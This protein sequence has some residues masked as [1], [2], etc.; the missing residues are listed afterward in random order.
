MYMYWKE[1]NLWM[2]LP[3]HSNIVPFDRVVLDELEGLF[4]AFTSV[5]IPGKSLKDNR[6]RVFKLPW[7]RQLTQVVDD[8]NLRYG[9][10]HQDIAPRNI[11]VDE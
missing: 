8:L 7:L 2:R 6:S 1:L 9:I 3:H 10:A 4:I 11:L 5:F